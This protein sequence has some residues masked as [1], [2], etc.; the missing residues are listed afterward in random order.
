MAFAT[1][2]PAGRPEPGHPASVVI[3]GAGQG[4]YQTAAS[5]RDHGYRGRLV[6][7]DAEDGLPYERPPLSK[8][9]L[10][11]ETDEGRLWL[12]PVSY[13][14]RQSI[15]LVAG[16]VTALDP[17]ARTVRLADG[18]V[19]GYDHLVLATGAAPRTLAVP[20]AALRGVHTLRTARDAA[21]LR[22]SLGAA[23]HAVVVGAGFIGLEFAAAARRA[24]CE[25]TVV[26]AL[27]R[28]LARV[29]SARTAGHFTRLHRREGSRLLFGQGVAALHGDERD[30]VTAVELA[31]GTRLPADL[32]LAGIG[33]VPRTGLAAAAGLRVS[34]GIAVDSHLLTSDPHISAVG[35][36]AAFPQ[37]RSGNRLRLESVQNA[38]GHAETVAA[39][40]TGT[41][42]GYSELPWFWS[43]QFATT[44]QIAGL[45]EG[46][47]TEV[48]LGDDPDAFSV[49]LFR[50]GELQAVESVNRPTDHL[51]ARRLLDRGV[52]LNPVDA[53]APGFTLRG[54][55][56]S[57]RGGPAV[58]VG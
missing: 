51:A 27:D 25:V 16:S 13:Y 50:A 23:R 4:G 9:Y 10:R 39:R 57:H 17:A 48:V 2:A 14:A 38:V 40:L 41:A 55:L 24:G 11:G 34:G 44:V 49:L 36:C 43:D 52:V 30:R 20:G 53:A 45:D 47:D 18:P 3:I 32:V 12:R 46:H 35:D 6:L 54:H 7:I 29:V 8:A 15:E 22:S 5:L 19:F 56:A 33:V 31:D 58:P 28:P 1:G 37:V 21:A 42:R 26:E